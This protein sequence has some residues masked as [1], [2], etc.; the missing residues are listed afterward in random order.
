MTHY[1]TGE[2]FLNIF[3]FMN[4][5]ISSDPCRIPRDSSF[6]IFISNFNSHEFIFNKGLVFSIHII[7]LF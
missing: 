6:I 2:Q 7:M 3:Q 5:L 4:I 1:F